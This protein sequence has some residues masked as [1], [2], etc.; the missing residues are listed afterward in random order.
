MHLDSATLT[1]VVPVTVRLAR[2]DDLPKLEWFGQ[3]RRFRALYARSF[4]EQEAGRRLMLLA[5]VGGFPV[6][7]IFVSLRSGKA[8]GPLH[9]YFYAFRV[10]E[11]FRGLGIGSFLLAHAESAA[12]NAG[13]SRA[14]I[15]VA[16]TNS[17]AQRLYE[18]RGYRVFAE[19]PGRWE[20]RDHEGV[21]HQEHEPCWLLEKHL[22]AR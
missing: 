4:R 19:D 11:M 16:K 13:C 18:R 22:A 15:A 17:R 20:Y 9:A 21:I 8:S 5:D 1:V 10:L 2:H 14:L 3:Y 12:Q 7:H 6:G